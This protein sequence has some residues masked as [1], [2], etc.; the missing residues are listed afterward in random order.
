M[1][2]QSSRPRKP[3]VVV[4]VV[5]ALDPDGVLAVELEEPVVAVGLVV[6]ETAEVEA[7]SGS[8]DT[9]RG[10]V[11]L[12]VHE[13]TVELEPLHGLPSFSLYTSD[14]GITLYN[15]HM[16]HRLNCT[17]YFTAI[18]ATFSQREALNEHVDSDAC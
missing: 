13:E 5:T 8:S 16:H 6:E 10:P 9:R 12:D 11:E 1:L 4:V 7:A 2:P 3:S 15:V 14:L 17:E 18:K